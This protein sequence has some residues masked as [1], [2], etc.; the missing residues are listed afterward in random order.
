MDG[1]AIDFCLPIGQYPIFQLSI[2]SFS[3]IVFI[4]L[5]PPPSCLAFSP[6]FP[7]TRT[8]A[9]RGDNKD[10]GVGVGVEVL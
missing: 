4:S 2:F 1:W 5:R 8:H 7:L 6:I 9:E 3:Y 10:Y